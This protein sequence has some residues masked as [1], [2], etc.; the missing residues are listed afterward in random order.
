[1][2]RTFAIFILIVTFFIIAS[3]TF[4]YATGASVSSNPSS[5]S[6]SEDMFKDMKTK[7]PF[8]NVFSSFLLSVGDYAHNY[9]T[10]ILKENVTIDKI[11]F[12]KVVMLNANF[13]ENSANASGS[14]A[15]GI[16]RKVINEWFSAFRKITLIVCVASLVV[17]G[18]KI[19]LKTPGGKVGAYDILKKVL[20]SVMLV[21][22]FPYAMK[23]AYDLNEAIINM[24]QN[25]I[26]PNRYA[27][28]V[29]KLVQESEL[30]VSE[31][32]FR[33]PQYV[34]NI[35]SRVQAGSDEATLLFLNRLD[36][37]NESFDVMR[38][39]RAYAGITL[40]FVYVILWYVLL[41]QTYIMVFIYI[42]RY[43]VLAFLTA[44]YP[45]TII[46]Y[47][48]SGMTGKS[49]TS[50]NEWCKIYF[51]N[52]FLQTMHAV[53]YGVISGIIIT[54]IRDRNPSDMNWLLMI[55]AISFLFTGEKIL[56]QFWKAAV[57][58][59]NERSSLKSMIKTP[60]RAL[61]NMRG[62]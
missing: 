57:S 29:S 16:V 19:M 35:S 52:I 10:Q 27:T 13:F 60:G 9:L 58:T 4:S 5:T 47:I 28:N 12:N 34:S 54:Q 51:G 39:M 25:E 6:V 42:K 53:L 50:F 49:K 2:K 56:Q 59:D 46:G 55:I 31:L 22:F 43:I 15:T 1:M 14:E 33:S 32:E 37:Y 40:K 24:V 23:L 45:L 8:E 62:Q 20:L 21:F 17:A 38:I 26:V 61:K 30:Q 7:N 36:E 3:P 44:I 41:V 18:I 48:V 11:V